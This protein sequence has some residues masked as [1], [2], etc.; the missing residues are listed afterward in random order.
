MDYRKFK[1]DKEEKLVKVR[2]KGE[3]ILDLGKGERKNE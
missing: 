3:K 2:E 1:E